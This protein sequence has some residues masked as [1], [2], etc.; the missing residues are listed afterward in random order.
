M[1]KIDLKI[2]FVPVDSPKPL[3]DI[4]NDLVK[5]TVKKVL[6]N[7]EGKSY[8]IVDDVDKKI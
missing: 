3:N 2:V 5:D 7:H 6:S 8:N 4:V 1:Q